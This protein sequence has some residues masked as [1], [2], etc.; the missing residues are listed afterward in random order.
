VTAIH[1]IHQSVD[2]TAVIVIHLLAL[3]QEMD[4]VKLYLTYQNVT[5]MAVIAMSSTTIIQTVLLKD[6]IGWE[7]EF[8]TVDYTTQLA[9]VLMEEIVGT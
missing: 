5:L 4:F 6:L 7:M 9:V 3:E 2:L 1:M 8:V